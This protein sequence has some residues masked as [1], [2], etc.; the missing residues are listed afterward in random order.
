VPGLDEPDGVP[1]D[2]RAGLDSRE[3]A[4]ESPLDATENLGCDFGTLDMAPDG[5]SCAGVDLPFPSLFGDSDLCGVINSDP[6][7]YWLDAAPEV[8]AR[9]SLFREAAGVSGG[10]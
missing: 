10:D 3:A 8:E 7:L 2:A 6:A 9:P 4:C 5:S 1:A